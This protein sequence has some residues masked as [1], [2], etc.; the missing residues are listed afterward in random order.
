MHNRRRR[1]SLGHEGVDINN[2]SAP[3][4]IT[5]VPTHPLHYTKFPT[6]SFK[7]YWGLSPQE[8]RVGVPGSKTFDYASVWTMLSF[9]GTSFQVCAFTFPFP[10]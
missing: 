3:E 6:M 10:T 2:Q 4:P 5:D 7:A 9:S 8:Q 1:A